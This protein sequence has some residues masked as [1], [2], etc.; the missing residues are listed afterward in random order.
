MNAQSD[1]LTDVYVVGKILY[2]HGA[3]RY[4]VYHMYPTY[5]SAASI[6]SKPSSSMTALPFAGAVSFPPAREWALVEY[7]SGSLANTV[8]QR[9]C[10]MSL[11]SLQRQLQLWHHC[12]IKNTHMQLSQEANTIV[13][14]PRRSLRTFTPPYAYVLPCVFGLHC[15]YAPQTG[16]CVPCAEGVRVYFS[17]GKILGVN[18]PLRIMRNC[19]SS[20]KYVRSFFLSP[21]SHLTRE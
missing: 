8:N 16:Y 3:H 13:M 1:C 9:T 2:R 11:T 18:L 4:Q 17:E 15:I 12:S 14:I 20:G 5:Q 6:V 21:A 10:L 7:N 19:L